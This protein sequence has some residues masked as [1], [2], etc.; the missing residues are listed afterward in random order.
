MTVYL[1]IVHQ[2]VGSLQ[3]ALDDGTLRDDGLHPVVISQ[4]APGGHI[5]VKVRYGTLD[6]N[7][8]FVENLDKYEIRKC[9]VANVL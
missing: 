7:K 9:P 8:S 5:P 2:V 1:V 6:V 3:L 4:T